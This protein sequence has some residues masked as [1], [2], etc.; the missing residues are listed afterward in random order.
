MKKQ[1]L[2]FALVLGGLSMTSCTKD[3]VCS[4]DIG[5]GETFDTNAENLNKQQAQDA[6]AT[7]EEGGS[8][9]WKEM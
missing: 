4:C 9:T 5:G 1:T 3:Y 6:Q 7:C 2:I 8:C